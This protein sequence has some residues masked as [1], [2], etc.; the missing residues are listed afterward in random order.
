MSCATH[1]IRTAKF[2]VRIPRRTTKAQ[3]A[4]MLTL[5]RAGDV[6]QT[7]DPSIGRKVYSLVHSCHPE[8]T[9]ELYMADGVTTVARLAS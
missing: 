6:L 7:D 1:F 2:P 4:Q 8:A 3:L 5:L 9:Y